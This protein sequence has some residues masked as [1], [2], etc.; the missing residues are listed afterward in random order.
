MYGKL[1]FTVR[2][3]QNGSVLLIA[4]DQH[5]D[6]IISQGTFKIQCLEPNYIFDLVRV[7]WADLAYAN[8]WTIDILEESRPEEYEI[9]ETKFYPALKRYALV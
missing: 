2:M 5:N 4:K 8:D 7:N 9:V 3:D 1:L 6:K